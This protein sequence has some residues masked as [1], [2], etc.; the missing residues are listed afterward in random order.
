MNEEHDKLGRFAKKG[1][2]DYESKIQKTLG[3]EKPNF[4][5]EG[6]HIVANGDRYDSSEDHSNSLKEEERQTRKNIV[7]L[8]T[9]MGFD[10]EQSLQHYN[11]LSEE[12]KKKL[13]EIIEDR[14]IENKLE[15][16]YELPE[17]KTKIL[18]NY[19]EFLRRVAPFFDKV[20][21]DEIWKYMSLDLKKKYFGGN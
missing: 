13:N 8:L 9:N 5:H 2:G 1:Q 20:D 17:N 14:N 15:K 19:R 6:S 10:E 18:K 3:I 16:I 7:G 4:E 21:D 12:S 11:S